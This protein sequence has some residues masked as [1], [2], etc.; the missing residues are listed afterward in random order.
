MVCGWVIAGGGVWNPDLRAT[1]DSKARRLAV[2]EADALPQTT[3]AVLVGSLLS[4]SPCQ[5]L[6]VAACMKHVSVRSGYLCT[7]QAGLVVRI[8]LVLGSGF[9]EYS[10]PSALGQKCLSMG[11]LCG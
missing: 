6:G 4:R 9:G 3:I 2:L 10:C 7:V 8:V 5:N 11:A 1:D